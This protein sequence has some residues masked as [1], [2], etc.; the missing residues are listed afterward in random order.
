[1]PLLD[2]NLPGHSCSGEGGCQRFFI[3]NMLWQTEKSVHSSMKFLC[4]R[5]SFFFQSFLLTPIEATTLPIHRRFGLSL[6]K[7]HHSVW[8]KVL[9]T[10][11]G[12]TSINSFQHTLGN[13][14]ENKNSLCAWPWGWV[15]V[16][17]VPI[18]SRRL[19]D[20]DGLP[21]LFPS[22]KPRLSSLDWKSAGSN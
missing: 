10:E 13:Y 9:R 5:S 7:G 4:N 21:D 15:R 2:T 18:Q 3:N 19:A 6:S 20:L 11:A 8:R 16:A 1:M 14:L 22:E 12:P 17:Q